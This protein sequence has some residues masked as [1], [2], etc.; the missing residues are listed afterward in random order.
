[1]GSVVAS[2]DDGGVESQP[3]P[4]TRAASKTGGASDGGVDRRIRPRGGPPE[5]P[6]RGR[7]SL[8]PRRSLG[9]LYGLAD[10]LCAGSETTPDAGAARPRWQAWLMAFPSLRADRGRPHST[11]LQVMGLPH[12]L[13]A[14]GKIAPARFLLCGAK[15]ETRRSGKDHKFL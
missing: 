5:R 2:G 7:R 1:M 15:I 9:S 8:L 12:S 4:R 11:G 13:A 3:R 6:A 10:A 14:A